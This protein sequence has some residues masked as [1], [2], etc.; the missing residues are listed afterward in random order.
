[1]TTAI[2]IVA[3]VWLLFMLLPALTLVLRISGHR[4]PADFDANPQSMAGSHY[5]AWREPILRD[6]AW[7]RG[8]RREP[9]AITAADGVRLEADWYP[10]GARAVVLAHG[11]NATPLN[12]FA[13]IARAFIEAGW[14]VLAIRQRGHGP[15]GGRTTLG[16]KEAD[17]LKRWAR[18]V[19]A[20]PDIAGVAVYG[21]SM[22]GAAVILGADGDWPPGV[23]VLVADAAYASVERQLWHL[24]QMGPLVKRVMIPLI[25][26]IARLV[27]HVDVRRDG[28][29]ALRRARLPMFFIGGDADESVA[30]EEVRRAW[31]ACGAAKALCVVP[32]APHTLACRVGGEE[33]KKKLFA[34]IE[35]QFTKEE[36]PK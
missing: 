17:D 5:A 26:P 25:M 10:G 1:M 2:A 4:D 24:K 31:D 7:M 29:A 35:G 22:G 8:R 36:K 12:N 16:L 28:L 21:M 30:I 18:W 15:S 34:F 3:A 14:S 6:I 20:R 33:V 11:F 9:A 19:A 27:L 13:G 23:R 32:G